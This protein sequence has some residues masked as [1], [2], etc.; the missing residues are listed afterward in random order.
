MRLL[1]C[2]RVGRESVH[3]HNRSRLSCPLDTF[4]G[5][6]TLGQLSCEMTIFLK[7]NSVKHTLSKWKG[8][9]IWRTHDSHLLHIIKK[10]Y[11]QQSCVFPQNVLERFDF[12][13]CNVWEIRNHG[14]T[15]AWMLSNNTC[16]SAFSLNQGFPAA[17]ILVVDQVI[18]LRSP[19]IKNFDGAGL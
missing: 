12:P 16:M 8:M 4:R 17:H 13:Y 10:C 11:A 6:K 1:N 7:G 3:W 18:A 15:T 14:S 5:S 19:E 2:E 9:F